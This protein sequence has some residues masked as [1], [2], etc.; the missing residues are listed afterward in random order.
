VLSASIL[1]FQGHFLT[2]RTDAALADIDLAIQQLPDSPRA[3]IL[4][5]DALAALERAPEARTEYKQ[6]LQLD[7][8]SSIANVKL[9]LLDISDARV[10]TGKKLIEKARSQLAAQSVTPAIKAALSIAEMGVAVLGDA[11]VHLAAAQKYAAE[12]LGD[13][14]SDPTSRMQALI[15]Q[16]SFKL[17]RDDLTAA[18]DLL[19]QALNL[20]PSNPAPLL[21]IVDWAHNLKRDDV[22][23]HY[24]TRAE[25]I[26]P[27]F[28]AVRKFRLLL[29][30]TQ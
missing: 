16:A 27:D 30:P 18:D 24:L 28:P 4:R 22:A 11:E 29:G 20:A 26:A 17:V 25:R 1:R 15:V 3:H 10:V 13:P 7:P 9:G 2:G 8:L 5:G 6:A 23:Q 19:Q 14:A 21:V 12:V